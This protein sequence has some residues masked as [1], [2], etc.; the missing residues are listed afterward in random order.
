MAGIHRRDAIRNAVG[1]RGKTRRWTS[2]PTPLQRR[3]EVPQNQILDGIFLTHGHIGHYTGLMNLGR[4]VMGTKDVPVYVMPRM[5]GFLSNN[6]PWEQLVKL[7]NI[8]LK[9]INDGVSFQP[10]SRIKVTPFLVPH[11]DEYTETVGYKI[12]GPNRSAVFIPDIDKWEKWNQKIED[13]IRG[14]DAAY[15][16]GTFYDNSEIPGRNMSEIPHP[17]ITETMKRLRSLPDSEKNKVHFIH[18][19]HTNPVIR[20]DSEARKRIEEMGFHVA[21]EGERLGI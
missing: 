2:P 5:A 8:S 7:N 4:E 19:N 17:F 16:D 6:V 1:T 13:V 18:L 21:E 20:K 12:E 15:I 3:G 11:R 10:N 14:V 9:N